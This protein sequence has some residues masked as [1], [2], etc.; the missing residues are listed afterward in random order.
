MLWEPQGEN[1]N[2][3]MNTFYFCKYKLHVYFTG[4]DHNLKIYLTSS[5]FRRNG[6][7]LFDFNLSSDVNTECF[8]QLSSLCDRS[9]D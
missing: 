2:A 5:C 7:F 9:V 3:E 4:F 6:A 1:Q 8:W